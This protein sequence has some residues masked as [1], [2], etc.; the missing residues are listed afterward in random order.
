MLAQQ[1]TRPT[2][3][4]SVHTGSAKSSVS[5]RVCSLVRTTHDIIDDLQ[6]P[7]EQVLHERYRPFLE[8]LRQDSVVCE[9]ER[10]G[11]DVPGG[12]PWDVFLIKEDAHELRDRKS[13]VGLVNMLAVR[14]EDNQPIRTSLSWIA[15]SEECVRSKQGAERAEGRTLREVGDRLVDVL[16][17]A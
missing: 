15:T 4:Q 6:V 17:P 9:E 3:L 8:G 7:R 2:S 10:P 5:T 13:G 1:T 11:D 14:T 12:L 16:E